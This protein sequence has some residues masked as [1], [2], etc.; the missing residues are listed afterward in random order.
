MRIHR[1][2]ARP[3]G[4]LRLPRRTARL[5]LTVLYGAAFLACGAA[6]LAVVAYLLYGSTANAPSGNQPKAS[7]SAV[8]SGQVPAADVRQDGGYDLVPVRVPS[9]DIRPA[10][11]YDIVSFAT[12]VPAGRSSAAARAHRGRAG[13]ARCRGA[14]SGQ[15]RQASRS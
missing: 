12:P 13:E 5:R 15:L 4:R 6:V 11:R 9:A 7:A 2:R 10:G 3:S 8:L 1:R 14:G